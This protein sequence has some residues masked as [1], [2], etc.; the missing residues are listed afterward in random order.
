MPELTPS[1]LARQLS[2]FSHQPKERTCQVCGK[3]F[4]THGR[5]VYCSRPCKRR[6]YHARKE[7]PHAPPPSPE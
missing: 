4:T 7:A 6:A 3:V 2:A 5:G 1:E